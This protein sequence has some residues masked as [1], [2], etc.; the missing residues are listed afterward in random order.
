MI[1]ETERD[2]IKQEHGIG[3][4]RT[5]KINRDQHGYP[6]ELLEGEDDSGVTWRGWLCEGEGILDMYWDTRN[7]DGWGKD[8]RGRSLAD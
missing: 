8:P 1:T 6:D 7:R 5:I 4:V 3:N 2:A